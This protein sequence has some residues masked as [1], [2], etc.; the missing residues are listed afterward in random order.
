[1]FQLNEI[2]RK[3]YHQIGYKDII[4]EDELSVQDWDGICEYK[5]LSEEFIREFEDK[6]DWV[7]V[8][9][10]QTLSE[11]FIRDFKN[12]VFWHYVSGCQILSED[13]IREFEDKLTWRYISEYQNLSENFIVEFQNN[14]DWHVY[15]KRQRASFQI[16]KKFIV[17]TSY[18]DTNQF[19]TSHLTNKEKEEIE[20]LL[21]LRNLFIK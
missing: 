8:S 17:K 10:N 5:K 6:I 3:L 9:R 7:I 18:N 15:F 1:V 13:F 20:K 2:R 12:D 21:K 11:G 19:T 14:I 16:I 4:S